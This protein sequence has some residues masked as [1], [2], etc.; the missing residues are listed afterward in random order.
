MHSR[1]DFKLSRILI[2]LARSQTMNILQ[3]WYAINKKANHASSS[4]AAKKL[5][6]S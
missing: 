3:P 2:R 6:H 5:T 4:R 1:M